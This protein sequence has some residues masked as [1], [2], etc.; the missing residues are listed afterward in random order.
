MPLNPKDNPEEYR[1][2]ANRALARAMATLRYEDVM[3]ARGCGGITRRAKFQGYDGLW[4]CGVSVNDISALDIYRLNG[5]PISFRDEGEAEDP[6]PGTRYITIS[7]EQMEEY[8][9]KIEIIQEENRLR[10]EG[11]AQG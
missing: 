7:E 8:L 5:K 9:A 3:I 11:W 2:M 10:R 6:Q 4:I 1:A